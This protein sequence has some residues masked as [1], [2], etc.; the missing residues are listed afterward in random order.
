MDILKMT[1]LQIGKAIKDRKITAIDVVKAV[2]DTIEKKDKLINAYITVNREAAI[3]RANVVQEQIENGKL[4]SPLAGVPIAVKDNICTK[5]IKTTC[6]SKI[7]YNFN[8]V[9]N[10][11]VIEKLEN[12]GMIVLGKTNM[13]EFA[14][15][16]TCETSFFG[17]VCNPIDKNRVSG[18]SSGGSAAA[19][20]SG[21]AMISLGTDTGGSIRQPAAYCG[22]TGFKPTYGTVSR[23][24][25]VAYAS[26]LDQIGPIGKDVAD[27]TALY[28]I[29]AGKDILDSTSVDNTSSR[30]YNNLNNDIDS[31]KIAVPKQFLNYGLDGNIKSCIEGAIEVLKNLGVEISYIDIPDLDYLIPT[32][33]IIASAEAASNLSR[34][35]GV[36]YGFRPDGNE[37]IEDLYIKTRS[38]GFGKEVKKRILLGNFVLSSGY[39]DAYYLKAL[40]AKAIIIKN[41]QKVFNEFDAMLT[42]TVPNI[43][44]NLGECLNEPLKTYLSDEYTVLANLCGLPALS[45]PCGISDEGLPVGLQIIGNVMTD[46]KVLNIGHSFQKA[47]DYHKTILEVVE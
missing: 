30:Y 23:Y 28:D 32:Y 9:Y 7:L 36:K 37:G 40:K 47:T 44:P 2:L 42:P 12:A 21:E 38:E 5:G 27:C 45:V 13:D 41:L 43:A 33:Y 16:S 25:L 3:K 11:T 46:S 15:G 8:P 17:P 4:T 14:M 19:V 35:D 20:S 31:V 34:F 18:G 6:A 1:A 29:I 39:Y 10:A 22:V 26:S 24:G